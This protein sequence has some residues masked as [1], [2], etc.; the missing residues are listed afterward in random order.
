MRVRLNGLHQRDIRALMAVL[1][2]GGLLPKMP[3]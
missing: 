2:S 3:Y 1:R